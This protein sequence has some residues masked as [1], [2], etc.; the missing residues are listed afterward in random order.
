MSGAILPLPQY[1]FMAWCLVKKHRDNFTFTF[2]KIKCHPKNSVI[3][4]VS[5]S[6]HENVRVES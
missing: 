5:L 3:S 6:V 4:A 1:A 2:Y